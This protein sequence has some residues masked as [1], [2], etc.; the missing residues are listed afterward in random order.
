MIRRASTK[1]KLS[2]GGTRL[3]SSYHTPK[4]RSANRFQGKNTLGSFLRAGATSAC[5]RKLVNGIWYLVFSVSNNIR[6]AFICASGKGSLPLLSNSMPKETEFI[7]VT[8]P[9]FDLPACQ[10]R[11]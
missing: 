5:P 4:P 3:F 10:E 6:S 9:H 7:S 8:F 11:R 2:G 1:L